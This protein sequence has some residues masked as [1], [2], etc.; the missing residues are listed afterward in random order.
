MMSSSAASVVSRFIA[1]VD[2]LIAGVRVDPLQ[3]LAEDAV[4]EVIGTTPIS[5]IY[6]G[7]EEI[8]LLFGCTAQ[9]LIASG[10]VQQFDVIADGEEVAAFLN[11][12]LTTP[13]GEVYNA[14]VDPAGCWFRVVGDK[15][16]E[17]RLFPDT[18]Q[19]ETQL[20]G[21]RFVPNEARGSQSGGG[22]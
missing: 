1:S 21:R 12:R 18:T 14:Q 13:A 22:S 19:V 7:R 4:L 2:Q 6:R 16:V 15:L 10:S 5:G 20:F 9:R 3:Y 8:R 11:I 17:I